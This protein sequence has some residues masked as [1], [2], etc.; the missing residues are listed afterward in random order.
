[1]VRNLKLFVV[2]FELVESQQLHYLL[3]VNIYKVKIQEIINIVVVVWNICFQQED[4]IQFKEIIKN[5]DVEYVEVQQNIW[6]NN[7]I[8]Y[9]TK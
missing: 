2:G 6:G 4:I 1:M 5:I 7:S 3:I 9:V 8:T